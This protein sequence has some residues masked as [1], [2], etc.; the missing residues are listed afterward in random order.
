MQCLLTEQTQFQTAE[1]GLQQAAQAQRYVASKPEA[2]RA[3]H[4]QGE[5]VTWA[6]QIDS[7]KKQT[8]N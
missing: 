6:G 5:G 2:W 1:Q 4:S 7:G 8:G 3:D